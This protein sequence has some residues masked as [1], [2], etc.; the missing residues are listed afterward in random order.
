MRS[1]ILLVIVATVAALR[2]VLAHDPI[3]TKVTWD[4]EIAPLFQARCVSCHSPGG[5]APM[6]LATYEEARPWA[7]AVREEVLARRMPKWPVVRGYGDFANDPSLSP[8]EIALITA[9]AD[10]GAPKT[11]PSPAARPGRLEPARSLPHEDAA[12]LARSLTLPC[13]ST[14][15]PAGQMIALRPSLQEGASLRLDLRFPDGRTEPL[16]WIRNF[17]PQFAETYRLRMPVTLSRG[18]RLLADGATR[19]CRVTLETLLE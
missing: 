11:A 7:R 15:L 2:S 4:R 6:S 3:T 16:I 17:D 8:F 12:A 19:D 1:R 10:G 9:W 5:R 14:E 18:T 13:S